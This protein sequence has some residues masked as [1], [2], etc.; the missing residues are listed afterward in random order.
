M[1]EGRQPRVLLVCM[2]FQSVQFPSLGLGLLK[3]SL[4]RHGIPCDIRYASLDHA[5]E[6]GFDLYQLVA[7]TYPTV[8]SMVGDWIFSAALFDDDPDPGLRLLERVRR[9]DPEVVGL[10]GEDREDFCEG[11]ARARRGAGGFLD[12]LLDDLDAARYDVIG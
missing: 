3:P 6:I 2:P 4:T 7:V 11:A 8:L 9:A 1:A 12:R 10:F 5:R